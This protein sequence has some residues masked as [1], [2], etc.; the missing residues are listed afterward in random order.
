MKPISSS[1]SLLLV[2]A[3]C[4]ATPQ[5]VFGQDKAEVK[6]EKAA[7]AKTT[8]GKVEV[9]QDRIKSIQRKVFVKAG[10]WELEP[11]FALS[12]NDAFYQKMG[13]GASVLYHPVDNLGIELHGVYVGTIQTDMVGYFQQ[14]NEALPK[15]SNL[16]YYLTGGLQW[17]PL[18]GKLSFVTDDIVHFDAYLLAGFGMAYTETGAKFA[19]NLG[20]GLRY[21]FSSWLSI[22]L[23]VRDLIYTETFQL[24]VSRT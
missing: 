10:R 13:G 20:V 9:Q 1:F 4:L 18:Y 5:S 2:L 22:K 19:T 21:F 8:K 11:V 24:D 14:A 23:E 3:F 7:E 6:K 12:L 16:R 17:S 15:V